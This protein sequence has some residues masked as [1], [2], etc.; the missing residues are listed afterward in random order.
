MARSP[1]PVVTTL[2]TN[3][4]QGYTITPDPGYFVANVLVDGVAQGGIGS[5]VFTLV[6]AN[7]TITA[8]FQIDYTITASAGA[9][10]TITPSG[11]TSL[12]GGDSQSYAITSN[13]GFLIGDVV[14][15]GVS[16]G[17]LSSYTFTNVSANHTIT[18]LFQGAFTITASAGVGG[19]IVPSGT[20]TV[21]SGGSQ[22]YT[23]T[24]NPAYLIANVLVDG[25]SQGALG[26]YTFNSVAANH[27]IV[28]S[29][30]LGDY[31]IT[32]TAGSGKFGAHVEYQTGGSPQSVAVADL[33]GDGKP[34]IV[35]AG[36]GSNSVS[37]LLA[38]GAGGYAPHTDFPVGVS[39]R[40]VATGDLN[41]DGKQDLAVANGGSNTVSVLLGDGTGGFAPATGFSTGS[42]P[43]SVVIRDVSS[44]GKPDLIVADETSNRVSVL[45]GNGVGGFGAKTDFVTGNAPYSVAVI[46][47]SGDGKPDIWWR[48]RLRPPSRCCWATARAASARRRT[49]PPRTARAGSPFVI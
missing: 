19:G 3:A 12:G 5:Y 40:S 33:N 28:A 31:T 22:T 43:S 7:H 49:S 44:D 20:L 27:T 30:V 35:A 39:P 41:G 46:D 25:V 21:A 13:V 14:V 1:P 2:V 36:N 42:S 37:V 17:P 6:N 16:Q 48:I 23:I 26:T 15:D 47:V 10:G 9:G 29:F 45:L 4:N 32:S 11:V 24:P 38:N 8:Q 34:D 18:A